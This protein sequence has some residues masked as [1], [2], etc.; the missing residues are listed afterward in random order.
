MPA[1]NKYSLVGFGIQAGGEADTALPS[2]TW[3]PLAGSLGFKKELNPE[4]LD[5]ADR[6]HYDHLSF[7]KGQWWT[8]QIPIYLCSGAVS[9]LI[10]W[11]Q[12][13]DAN[14]Q[15]KFANV[16]ITQGVTG[17]GSL[18]TTGI[19]RRA[20]DVKVNSAEFVFTAGDPVRVNLNCTG[21]GDGEITNAPE[22]HATVLSAVQGN[23]FLWKEATLS[24]ASTEA[25]TLATDYT[26]KDI[27]VTIDNSVQDPAEGLRFNGSYNPYRLYNTGGIKVSGSFTRDMC[28]TALYNAY[29]NQYTS[30]AWYSSA[31]NIQ[32][33]IVIAAIGLTGLT[34]L[35][36]SVRITEYEAQPSGERR[37]LITESVSFEAFGSADGET[38]PITLS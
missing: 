7:S 36:P 6:N 2:F 4:V 26:I 1:L 8:G 35:M 33:R 37:S 3:L 38:K 14:N 31:Y 25:G 32:L 23:P 19:W 21:K 27:Q 18:S 16:W 22:G 30:A 11:I 34:L 29:N 15:G 17:N 24:I 20:V 13:R 9:N 12:T 28:D 5:M 10:D